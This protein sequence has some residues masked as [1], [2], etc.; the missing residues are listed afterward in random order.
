MVAPVASATV[1]PALPHCPNF[2]LRRIL[3]SMN[4]SHR[5]ETTC[6]SPSSCLKGKC[7]SFSSEQ[8]GCPASL[9]A[10]TDMLSH[11]PSTLA[12]RSLPDACCCPEWPG[13]GWGSPGWGAISCL[14]LTPAATQGHSLITADTQT[15]HSATT[16]LPSRGGS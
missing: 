15:D 14:S 12:Q 8:G 4:R 11:A 2:V 6:A 7:V 5:R 1:Q 13:V 16:T 10:V 9:P 3:H